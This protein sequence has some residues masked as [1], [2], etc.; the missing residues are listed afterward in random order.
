MSSETSLPWLVQNKPS[1]P[2]RRVE[3]RLNSS[4]DNFIAKSFRLSTKRKLSIL[5]NFL[6]PFVSFIGVFSILKCKTLVLKTTTSWSRPRREY[7][8][9]VE[10]IVSQTHQLSKDSLT[11]LVSQEVRSKRLKELDQRAERLKEKAPKKTQR[12]LNLAREKVSSAWLRCFP[13]RIWA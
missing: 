4:K 10:Q 11:K 1:T 8:S 12:A 3:T 13:S 2:I 9:S 7:A 6:F 5:L